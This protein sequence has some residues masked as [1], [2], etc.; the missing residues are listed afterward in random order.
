MTKYKA[1]V[2]SNTR[3]NQNLSHSKNHHLTMF[4]YLTSYSCILLGDCICSD[5]DD[6]FYCDHKYLDDAL[7]DG[8][9]LN[10]RRPCL[11]VDD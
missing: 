11:T 10:D 4:G 7:C 2:R 3:H 8:G 9:R 6:A 5:V 1:F